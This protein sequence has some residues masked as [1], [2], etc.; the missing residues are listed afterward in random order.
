MVVFDC[1]LGGEAFVTRV[2]WTLASVS[3]EESRI[4]YR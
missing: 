4:K 2:K 1:I 3:K